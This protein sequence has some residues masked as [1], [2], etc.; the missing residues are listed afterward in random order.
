MDAVKPSKQKF[1]EFISKAY[2]KGLTIDI[3]DFSYSINEDEAKGLAEE[4]SQI[5]GIGF[6]KSK[7]SSTQAFVLGDSKSK[8]RGQFFYGPVNFLEEDVD[9]SGSEGISETN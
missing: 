3:A 6:K 4:L 9:L 8:V 2:D 1:M 7:F 5:T